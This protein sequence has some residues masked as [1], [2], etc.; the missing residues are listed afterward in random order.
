MSQE[1]RDESIFAPARFF[2]LAAARLATGP[3]PGESELQG[4]HVLNPDLADVAFSYRDA[5]VLIPAIAREPGVTVLLTERT[6]HLTAHAGQIAFPGGKIDPTDADPTATALRET[7]EEIGLDAGAISI[8]GALTP[9][10]SRTGYRIFP[11]LG[12]VEPEFALTL[13]RDEVEGVFEVPLSFLMTEEN[14]RR[15]S[16]I[17]AGRPRT[18][19]EIPYEGHYIWGVTAGIIR[20][21]YERIFD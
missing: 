15:A 11:I 3:T 9:Y 10:L 1:D 17:F 4:D 19:Y 14:H 20:G 7:K 8:V 21:L 2:P 16:R 6:A 12:R 13:N 18:F 5:A